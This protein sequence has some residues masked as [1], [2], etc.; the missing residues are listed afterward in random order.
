M[1]EQWDKEP[2]PVPYGQDR[3]RQTAKD[4]ILSSNEQGDPSSVTQGVNQ[5]SSNSPSVQDITNTPAACSFWERMA[6]FEVYN[7]QKQRIA[8]EQQAMLF[9][10]ALKTLSSKEYLLDS[11]EAFA[12]GD[13]SDKDQTA[14]SISGSLV[15]GFFDVDLPLDFR[16]FIYDI[17]HI[18]ELE[19]PVRRILFDLG[20][21]F[22]F[23]GMIKPVKYADDAAEIIKHADDI[24][25]ALDGLGDTARQLDNVGDAAADISRASVKQ[26][27][28][29]DELAHSGVKYNPE[30]VISVIK[31]S[32]GTLMWL[33]KGNEASGLTHI[34]KNHADD[35]AAKGID[36]IPSFL[37]EVLSTN[38]IRTGSNSKGPFADFLLDGNEYRV[39]YGTN[40]Y[41]VSFYPID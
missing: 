11:A 20:M 4:T 35:F 39:A 29:L 14:L 30:D 1:C 10:R 26:L 36:D 37:E 18:D 5:F 34:I 16:D 7:T 6:A 3:D 23:I 9:L 12:L 21:F 8:Q 2:S 33:E 13:F 25:D 22:P 41:I 19:H 15:A 38:P 27:E 17:S 28:L 40:G 24:G 32:D 31:R